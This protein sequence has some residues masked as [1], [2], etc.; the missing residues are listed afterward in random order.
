MKVKKIKFKIMFFLLCMISS[1]GQT[2][3]PKYILVSKLFYSHDGM[4]IVAR[5]DEGIDSINIP[6]DTSKIKI[7]LIN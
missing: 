2:D 5:Y 6:I 4:G 1:Y 3:K 7:K